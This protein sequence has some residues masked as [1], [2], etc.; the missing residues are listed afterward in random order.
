MKDKGW[1][2]GYT[3]HMLPTEVENILFYLSALRCENQTR[4]DG[5]TIGGDCGPP[6]EIGF[7]EF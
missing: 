3:L 5:Q 6:R 2:L 7:F 4:A 1:Q